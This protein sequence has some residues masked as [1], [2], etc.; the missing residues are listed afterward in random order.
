MKATYFFS[1]ILVSIL[2][3]TSCATKSSRMITS[4]DTADAVTTPTP[5]V[6]TT[7]SANPDYTREHEL[8]HICDHKEHTHNCAHIKTTTVDSTNELLEEM[9]VYLAKRQLKSNASEEKLYENLEKKLISENIEKAHFAWDES[10]TAPSA[11]LDQVWEKS[12]SKKTV[13][14]NSSAIAKSSTDYTAQQTTEDASVEESTETDAVWE[15]A[16]TK[17]TKT[18]NLNNGSSVNRK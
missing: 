3:G 12:A 6:N 11:D 8:D 18:V 2:L 5:P 16:A 15:K 10:S 17:K 1:T 4:D 13:T 9:K 14:T 7:A